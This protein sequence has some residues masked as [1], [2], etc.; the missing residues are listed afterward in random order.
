[1]AAQFHFWEHINGNQTIILD[2]HRPFSCSGIC[3]LVHVHVPLVT[4]CFISTHL[5]LQCY[6][7]NFLL[8]FSILSFCYVPLRLTQ[9]CILFLLCFLS[10]PPFLYLLFLSLSFLVFFC[11]QEEVETWRRASHRRKNP[12][13]SLS[14]YVCITSDG[15]MRREDIG[16][17]V[18]LC[19]YCICSTVELGTQQSNSECSQPTP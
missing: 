13:R 16:V 19:I 8:Y 17:V 3:F 11:S 15:R 5:S 10:F 9:R 18:L 12:K 2:S 4:P 7:L 1:V 6:S 14:G